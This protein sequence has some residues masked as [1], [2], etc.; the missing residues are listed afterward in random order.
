MGTDTVGTG[1]VRGAICATLFVAGLWA[2]PSAEKRSSPIVKSGVCQRQGESVVGRRPE[3]I[4][5][6]VR[7]PTKTRS[8][9]PKYPELPPGTTGR[10]KWIGEALVDS[11]GKVVRVWAIREVKITPP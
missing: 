11:G 1:N 4:G 2:N 8:V 9:S 6:T 10:G 7:A 5:G 3:K